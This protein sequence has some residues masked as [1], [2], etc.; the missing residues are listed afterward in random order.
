MLPPLIRG[1]LGMALC[2]AACHCH[3]CASVMR[4]EYGSIGRKRVKAIV[5]HQ[6]GPPE[7]LHLEQVPAPAP[8][9][10]ELLLKVHAVSV[11]RTLD[12]AVRAGQYVHRPKL[13]HVLGVDPCGVVAAVG[14]EVTTRKVG[15]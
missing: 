3:S 14:P 5:F 2:M 13:P 7:V 10:G 8:G 9:P 6:F 4:S 12:L 1:S 11:N 15:D